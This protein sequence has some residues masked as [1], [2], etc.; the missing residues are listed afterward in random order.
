M[1]KKTQKKNVIGYAFCGSFCTLAS[2]IRVLE[3]LLADY[4]VIPIFSEKMASY[5]TR[6]GRAEELTGRI[7]T[8]C[9]HTAI[10]TVVEAERIGPEKL[11]D[12]LVIAPC[13]GNTLA[14]LARGMVDSAVPMAAKAHLRN[15]RP[16]LIALASNDALSAGLSNLGEV[17]LRKNIYLVPLGQD[18]PQGKPTSL[19]ADFEKIPEALAEALAGRQIQPLLLRQ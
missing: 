2:S 15:N 9:G 14:K 3:K 16:L 10:R 17:I 11:F 12:A 1:E 18:D 7:E 6:F 8:L 4:E 13:T 19:V 5:D